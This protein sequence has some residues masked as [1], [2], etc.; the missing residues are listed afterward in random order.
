MRS[1]DA[2]S[3]DRSF[4]AG[5]H[6]GRTENQPGL[7]R[8]KPGR[9]RLLSSHPA[10]RQTLQQRGGVFASG[11][12]PP[13]SESAHS[14]F[15]DANFVRRQP[16]DRGR[17]RTQRTARSN[18]CRQRS[19]PCGGRVQ[20]PPITAALWHRPGGRPGRVADRR[21]PRFARGPR[22]AGSSS[23]DDVLVHRHRKHD[24]SAKCGRFCP[25]G[26]RWPR[27]TKLKRRRDWRILPHA[28][29]S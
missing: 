26:K 3:V 16:R 25:L 24:D 27:A 10:Q 6:R 14:R 20:F 12:A 8:P 4:H 17:D 15:D 23:C 1:A 7:Q 21:P 13:Q 28:R 19:H 11:D 9:R 18:S 22:A 29:R 5:G 2:P